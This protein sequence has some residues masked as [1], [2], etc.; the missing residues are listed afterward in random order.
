MS[1]CP[2]WKVFQWPTFMDMLPA[3]NLFGHDAKPCWTLSQTKNLNFRTHHSSIVFSNGNRMRFNL[4]AKVGLYMK[5]FPILEIYS[6]PYTNRRVNKSFLIFLFKGILKYLNFSD[7]YS[8]F[9]N[10]SVYM[11]TDEVR[12]SLF[13]R[14]RGQHLSPAVAEIKNFA[15]VDILLFFHQQIPAALLRRRCPSRRPVVPLL[16]TRTTNVFLHLLVTSRNFKTND[17]LDT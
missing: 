14:L 9:S 2:D 3:M 1:R 7:L 16:E 10:V 12:S 5:P 17:M 15:L 6:H 4:I 13:G 8:K 11:L